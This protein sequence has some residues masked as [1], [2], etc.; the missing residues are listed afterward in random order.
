MAAVGL[1]AAV[2]VSAAGA[3]ARSSDG[4]QCLASWY[5]DPDQPV[6]TASGELLDPAALTAAHRTL[7]FGSR[8]RVVNRNDGRA[9]EVR[10]NDR[11]PHTEGRCVNLTR[12]A[13]EAIAPLSAGVAPIT[14]QVLSGEDDP[15][16][17]TT[18]PP[19]PPASPTPAAA[20]SSPSSTAPNG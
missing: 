1:L 12:A 3:E 15:A 11:G 18:T 19:S 8:I 4:E 14:V 16:I 17:P 5:G 2:A 10:I 20:A 9:V 13:F 6:H 7:V